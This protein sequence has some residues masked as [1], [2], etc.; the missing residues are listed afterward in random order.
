MAIHMHSKTGD[1]QQLGHDL[2]NAPNQV[3]GKQ[4]KCDPVFCTSPTMNA[5][6]ESDGSDDEHVADDNS[7][8]ADKPTLPEQ[9]DGI[10]SEELDA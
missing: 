5:S 3:L 9:I 6:S 2:R 4:S 7:S 1:V 8:G 10:I